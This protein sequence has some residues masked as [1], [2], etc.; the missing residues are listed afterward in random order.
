MNS[1]H[2]HTIVSIS[3]A[4]HCCGEICE[5]VVAGHSIF[6]MLAGKA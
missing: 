4:M 2:I 1:D 5:N 6:L 3:I